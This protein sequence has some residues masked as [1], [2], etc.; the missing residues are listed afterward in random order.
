MNRTSNS[1]AACKNAFADWETELC[2]KATGDEGETLAWRSHLPWTHEQIFQ[3]ER[4]K[5]INA[6]SEVW[7]YD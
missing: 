1:K 3:T 7:N 5:A 6:I 4:V 2:L